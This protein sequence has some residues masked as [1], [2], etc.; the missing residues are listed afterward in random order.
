MF[1]SENKKIVKDLQKKE[2]D[3]ISKQ[4]KDINGFLP[5]KKHQT[6]TGVIAIDDKAK[7]IALKSAETNINNF[8]YS[9]ILKCEV[10]EDG[11]TISMK[12]NTIGRA[13]VGGLIAGGTGAIVGGLSGKEKQSKEV[14]FLDLKIVLKDI[15]NPSYKIRFFDAKQISDDT[16][17]S[18]CIS[19][20][21]Y[22]DQL[23]EAVGQITKWKD[24]IDV[25]IDKNS[26]KSEVAETPALSISDELIKLKNL[27]EE[28]VI[29]DEEFKQQKQKLLNK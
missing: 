23:K 26:A 21:L 27:V 17:E 16:K 18:I 1:V 4:L 25:I 8:G 5:T 15:D 10:I 12:T 11:V 19:D 14:K 2:Y 29:S 20:S 24:R 28:G 13:L 3:E 9:E 22:G 7:R 6:S